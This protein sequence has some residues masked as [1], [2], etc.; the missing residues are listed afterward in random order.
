MPNMKY[1]GS[2]VK[3]ER[4]AIFKLFLNN[5]RLK[6]SD[7]EKALTIRSNM[8]AYHLKEMEKEGLL[9]KDTEYYVLTKNAEK[10]IPIFSH[11]I[12]QDLSPLPVV[13]VAV[14][15]NNKILLIK[16]NKRPYKDYWSMIGGKMRLEE[17][18]EEASLRLVKDKTGL[19]GDFVSINSILHERVHEDTVK[20][21]F[22]LFFTK[23]KAKN[24]YFKEKEHGI[25]KWFNPNKLDKDEVIPSDYWL[26]KH[27]LEKKV[28]MII[29]HMKDKEGTLQDFKVHKLNKIQ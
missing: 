7:I 23:V 8:V 26:I 14:M 12:G 9:R 29:A 20:H 13:L 2:L 3:K 27:K 15:H 11:V 1:S 18:F 4:E 22:I 6:F 28:D 21:S 19:D 24:I 10:Y 5:D 25:L 17:G 16:R